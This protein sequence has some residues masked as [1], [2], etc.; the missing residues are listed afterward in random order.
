MPTVKNQFKPFVCKH[1]IE[2]GTAH[3]DSLLC[4]LEES[5]ETFQSCE[6]SQTMFEFSQKLI[7]NHPKSQLVKIYQG[8]SETRLAD[9]LANIND[10]A[11]IFLD[12]HYAGPPMALGESFCPL[13]KEI[14]IIKNHSI[15][16]HTIMIDDIRCCGTH[17]FKGISV[18]DLIKWIQEINPNYKF[19]TVDCEYP[20][21]ILVAYI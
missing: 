15:K 12:A 14:E 10:Q 9:M 19:K 6:L 3:G 7:S 17:L 4:A 18:D 13:D 11:T 8:P 20:N 21:D 16:T 2:T 5:F 1:Y